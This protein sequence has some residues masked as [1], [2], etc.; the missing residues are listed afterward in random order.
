MPI[1]EATKTTT[2]AT[3]EE[4][5]KEKK[6]VVVRGLKMVFLLDCLF[7][8]LHIAQAAQTCRDK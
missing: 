1:S 6:S 4:R 5:K 3:K 7:L 8:S 2:T